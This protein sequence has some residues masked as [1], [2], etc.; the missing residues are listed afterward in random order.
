[1]LG[2]SA[3]SGMVAVSRRRAFTARI[4][5][6]VLAVVRGM[7]G[8]P[9]GPVVQRHRLLVALRVQERLAAAGCNHG[10]VMTGI[11]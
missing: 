5:R 6:P 3:S 11:P 1:M 9:P 7:R 8:R 4:G 10:L 2:R